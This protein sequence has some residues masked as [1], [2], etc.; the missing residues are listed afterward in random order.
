MDQS[1]AACHALAAGPG[2][3]AERRSAFVRRLALGCAALVLAVTSLSAFIR[4][5]KAGLSCA[6]WPQCYAQGLR[7]LQQG[8]PAEAGEDAAT[9]AARLVHRVVASAAL[10][11]VIAILA[12]CLTARPVPWPQV[13]VGLA[14]L[15]LALFL[16]ILGRWSGAA[17]VPAVAMGNL[18]G[19]FA[20]LALSWRLAW[21]GEV[22]ASRAL[23][24]AAWGAVSLLTAQIALGGLLSASFAATSC[25][26]GLADC[27]VA[28]RE[29]P[30]AAL[31]P[32][33]EPLPAA[34]PPVN[35]DGALVQAAHRLCG[36][37][38]VLV[39][40]GLG[41]A[42]LR[43]GRRGAGGLL[44]VELALVLGLGVTMSESRPTLALALAHNV[45]AALLLATCFELTR[46]PPR[47]PP[48]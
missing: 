39:V 6:D 45:G 43:G 14:L 17:R 18:L 29:V 1:H 46:G 38:V 12:A 41:V 44:L 21:R 34:V 24:A 37:A 36:I 27:I 13:H 5:S 10:L 15:A 26:P 33:R 22:T 19:G 9:A 8:R 11:L 16:A 32:W 48:G 20:M 4:L 35:P 2:A 31:D 23:R 40:G 28:A 47:P 25:P 30:L 42:A 3:Q 7:E